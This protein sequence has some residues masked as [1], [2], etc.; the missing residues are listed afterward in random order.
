M[1]MSTSVVFLRSKEDEQYQKYLKVFLACKE[2]GM[3]LPEEIDAYFG[4]EDD[5]DAP[6][7]VKCKPRKWSNEYAEGFEIDVDEIPKGVKT[8]R[9]YNSW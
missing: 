4:G 1:G 5:I 7:E 8:I 6:L 2:A 3:G 9:F